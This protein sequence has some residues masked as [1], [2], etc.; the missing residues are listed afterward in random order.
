MN[1][2][3]N[4][5]K[6]IKESSHENIQEYNV[7]NYKIFLYI[8]LL[9]KHLIEEISTEINNETI[10][11]LKISNDPNKNK[12]D[13]AI[14]AELHLRIARASKNKRC[15]LAYL[16][17]RMNKIEN[18]VWKLT[19]HLP[20][21]IVT[22]LDEKDKKY[23]EEYNTLINKYSQTIGFSDMDLTKDYAPPKNLYIE[24]RALENVNCTK[25]DGDEMK[26]ITYEKNHTYSIKRNEIEHYLRVG[27]FAIN[28]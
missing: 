7:Y 27:K 10:E 16:S 15:L 21:Q 28:E 19:G 4:G 3:Q 13:L 26:A 6:L 25:K 24:V 5:I 18:L 22:K 14:K 23:Y 1:F 17:D 11:I 9:Q 20:E 8:R 2:C 12:D